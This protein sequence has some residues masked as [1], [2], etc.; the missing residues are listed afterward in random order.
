MDAAPGKGVERAP[1]CRASYPLSFFEMSF[2]PA[3]FPQGGRAANDALDFLYF[4]RVYNPRVWT[5]P[6]RHLSVGIEDVPT[7]HGGSAQR[8]C[9]H[10]HLE[11]RPRG[12]RGPYVLPMG[13][14]SERG[15]DLMSPTRTHG[16]RGWIGF[17]QPVLRVAFPF[18]EATRVTH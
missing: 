17:R 13:H 5:N 3:A 16:R 1:S 18:E 7:R 6:G 2:P 9:L 4:T 10:P 14:A 12:F 11:A 15:H 8:L